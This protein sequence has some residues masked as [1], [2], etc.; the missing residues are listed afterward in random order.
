MPRGRLA[1]RGSMQ[2]RWNG[3]NFEPHPSVSKIPRTVWWCQ[4]KSDNEAA[5][6]PQPQP[7]PQHEIRRPANHSS[8]QARHK[9]RR[10][11]RCHDCLRDI[12]PREGEKSRLSKSA[13]TVKAD[14]EYSIRLAPG[15][16]FHAPGVSIVLHNG[17]WHEG[18]KS[19]RDWVHSWYRYAG[20]SVAWLRSAPYARRDYPVG[21]TDLLFDEAHNLYTFGKYTFGKLL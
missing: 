3:P 12:Y 2:I 4:Q 18:F 1:Y 13:A 19:Y 20:A 14:V 16:S 8:S 7:L 9:L 11:C 10:D 5:L 15:E 17:D 21:G 6:R